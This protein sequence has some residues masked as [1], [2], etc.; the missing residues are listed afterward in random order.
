MIELPN[1]YCFVNHADW[2][3]RQLG[4][5]GSRGGPVLQKKGVTDVFFHHSVTSVS[6][7]P[8]LAGTRDP[9]DDPCKDARLIE[10]ILASR[11]LLPGYSYLIHPSGVVLECA[12]DYIGAHTENHNSSSKGICLIGNYDIQQPTLAQLVAAA[13]TI[14]L[15]RAGGQLAGDLSKINL[16]GHR[17]S[18]STACPGANFYPIIGFIRKFAADNN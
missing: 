4:G 2:S 6:G 13:R 9:S 14:N 18:K 5:R 15:M 3:K 10:D 16:M 7:D 11:G 12:G 1:G 17:D 8:A